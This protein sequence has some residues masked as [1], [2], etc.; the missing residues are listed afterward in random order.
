MLSII[1][2]T[3]LKCYLETNDSFVASLIRLNNCH[4][5]ESEKILKSYKKFGELIIL[6]QTKGELIE[7]LF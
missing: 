3:L 7:D 6:Y 4:L 5:E 1:D 2:T